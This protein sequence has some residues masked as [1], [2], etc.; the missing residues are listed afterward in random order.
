MRKI[1]FLVVLLSSFFSFGQNKKVN[2]TVESRA[3][4]DHASHGYVRCSTTEY[5]EC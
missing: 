1:T 4:H 2:T 3:P 5:E